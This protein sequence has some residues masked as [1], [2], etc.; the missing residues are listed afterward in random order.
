[1]NTSHT[2]ADSVLPLT[3][4]RTIPGL[5][6]ENYWFRRHEVVYQQLAQHC[7]DREVLEAGCG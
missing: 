7:A 5:D 4:E 6:V 2:P 3:G 1:M